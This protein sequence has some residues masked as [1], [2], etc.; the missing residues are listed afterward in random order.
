MGLSTHRIPSLGCRSPRGVTHVRSMM[1][2]ISVSGIYSNLRTTRL[3]L[4]CLFILIH[5]QRVLIPCN[6]NINYTGAI[7]LN[8]KKC[9]NILLLHSRFEKIVSE[10]VLDVLFSST[11]R[12]PNSS[13]QKRAVGNGSSTYSHICGVP[14]QRRPPPSLWEAM[15]HL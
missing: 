4:R 5:V 9:I 11:M 8:R 10:I 1:L 2:N 15:V 3:S 7:K 12:M 13:T 14:L 6:I